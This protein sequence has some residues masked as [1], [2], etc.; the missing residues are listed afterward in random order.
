MF[1]NKT[2]KACDFDTF[3]D[4]N[5]YEDKLAEVYNL[6]IGAPPCEGALVDY[7]ITKNFKIENGDLTWTADG[8][9]DKFEV[10]NGTYCID[11]S[12][13]KEK[14]MLRK[15][16]EFQ[17]ACE[18]R[19]CV[20][21]CCPH[22]HIYL[23]SARQRATCIM[24]WNLTFVSNFRDVYGNIMNR[25][26]DVAVL[27]K[28]VCTHSRYVLNRHEF[29]ILP[30]GTLKFG[31]MY[32]NATEKQFCIENIL[33]PRTKVMSEVATVCFPAPTMNYDWYYFS[34]LVVSILCLALT[35][36][37]YFMLPELQN[38]H[39][40][41]VMCHT[42]SLLLAYI[43]L[44]LVKRPLTAFGVVPCTVLG[45]CILFN[46]AS[47]FS[48]LNVMCF[49]IWWTFGAMNVRLGKSNK[50]K[51]FLFYC[52]FAYGLPLVLTSIAV[53]CDYLDSIPAAYK[54]HIG[55]N[56][57][58]F[59]L[60][61]LGHTLYFGLPMGFLI[62][63]NLVLFILTARNCFKIK[64][65]IARLR[66]TEHKKKRFLADRATLI[67]N[68]KLFIV[69]GITWVF[70]FVSTYV[71]EPAWLWMSIDT[72]N[73]LQ[74]LWIFCIFVIKDKVW[75]SLRHQ[76]GCRFVDVSQNTQTT[77]TSTHKNSVC[78]MTS[79]K[80]NGVKPEELE[81][82]QNSLKESSEWSKQTEIAVDNDTGKLQ[83]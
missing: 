33:N 60:N 71:K 2:R 44:A 26:S 42:V 63:C 12:R 17:E 20:S 62:A 9:V 30:N 51:R 66:D 67:M 56:S 3:A 11:R 58:W 7:S 40:K 68:V 64:A 10:K 57:C 76:L 34:G 28:Q 54:P 61:K 47:A 27:P 25:P 65:D 23:L 24:D 50:A 82:I 39:G 31:T 70:E 49:D 72:L 19:I 29:F 14:I 73:T 75:K 59:D 69:M 35:L 53:T 13:N 37:V 83:P 43:C 15:C 16:E 46:F 78:S 41:T 8:T 77:N 36:F 55:R 74:G 80:V 18:G 45:Y 81:L 48:W 21:K 6:E 38:L 22:G 52:L 1:Y 32:L 5:L 4:Q 79:L